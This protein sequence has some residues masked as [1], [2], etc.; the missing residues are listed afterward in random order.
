MIDIG[1]EPP[2]EPVD[3][4]IV[5]CQCDEC[6]DD[7]YVGEDLYRLGGKCY[8]HWCVESNRED[9]GCYD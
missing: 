2:L 8:C 5:V 1:I 4:R 3:D 9:A 6:H 7:I